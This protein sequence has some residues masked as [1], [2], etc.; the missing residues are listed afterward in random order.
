M[1]GSEGEGKKETITKE[2][3]KKGKKKFTGLAGA[4]EQKTLSRSGVPYVA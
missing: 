4:G 1:K 3:E 2:K